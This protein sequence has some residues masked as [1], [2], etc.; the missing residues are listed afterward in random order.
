MKILILG[1]S[2]MLGSEVKKVFIGNTLILPDEK[3]LNIT[4]ENRVLEF[5][6]EEKP[7]VIIN[8]AAYTNVD[9]C[10][11]E[12]NKKIAFKVNGYGPG[13]LAKGAKEVR[14]KLVHIS[15][16]YVFAG[17]KKT[18]YE[19]DDPV[20]PINAYGET[21]LLGE[22]EIKKNCDSYYILRTA[23]LYGENGPNFIDTMLKLGKEKSE[24]KVVN[25]QYGSPTNVKDLAKGIKN[26]ISQDKYGIYHM[27]NHGY[28][29]WY[30]LA[31]LVF[32]YADMKVKVDPVSSVE[33]IRPAKRPSNS[34]IND[35]KLVE[36]GYELLRNY[37]DAVKEFIEEKNL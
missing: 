9:G 37:E 29:S 35:R 10:E 16:D 30:D 4:D 11:S 26:I 31:V 25:D 6:K 5:I 15:T 20:D 33:L 21:K 19:T 14:A 7:E 32:K 17:D 13:Y 28:C 24:I 3:E 22:N 1:S 34:R 18:P 2:G 36:N 23:W 27:V 8:C 12:D